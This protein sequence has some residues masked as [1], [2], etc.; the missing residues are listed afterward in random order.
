MFLP[1]QNTAKGQ[2]LKPTMLQ[3]E[4]GER[5]STAA[6]NEKA[7]WLLLLQSA[8]FAGFVLLK[9]R[10]EHS[11]LLVAVMISLNMHAA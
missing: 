11:S 8:I 7:A 5:L 4:P 2:R 6:A 1:Y 9:C 10:S 3:H